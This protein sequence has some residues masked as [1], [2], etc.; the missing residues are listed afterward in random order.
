MVAGC[1][2]VRIKPLKVPVVAQDPKSYLALLKVSA[3]FKR[4]AM[5][6]DGAVRKGE[7]VVVNKLDALKMARATGDIPQNVNFAIKGSIAHDF[8]A[9]HGVTAVIAP[10]TTDLPAADV[11]ER[12]Q[13]YTA[14]IECWK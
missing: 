2:E 5:F 10:S 9:K 3:N 7:G 14:L 1:R 4:F 11:A 12:A 13:F 8:M 6:R